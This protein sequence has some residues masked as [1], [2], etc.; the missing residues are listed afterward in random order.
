[1][2]KRKIPIGTQAMTG[3]FLSSKNEEPVYFESRLEKDFYTLLEFDKRVKSYSEQ[4][5]R[6]EYY[7]NGRNRIYTPDVL[8]HFHKEESCLCEVKFRSDLRDNFSAY[9]PK[10]RAANE[11]SIS[12]G[13]KF[14]LVTEDHIRTDYLE[15]AK[16]LMRFKKFEAN[17]FEETQVVK[18]LI[19]NYKGL[20]FSPQ[21]VR[22]GIGSTWETK[23]ILMTYFWRLVYTEH[24]CFDQTRKLSMSTEMWLND[25]YYGG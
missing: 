11:Y 10:F 25:H 7:D 23:A 1:M 5:V 24:I 4:L 8:V 22:D 16:F 3:S 15:N 17:P 14:K 2:V 13:W 19:A 12:Q 20:F 6:I 21:Q 9:K 18:F